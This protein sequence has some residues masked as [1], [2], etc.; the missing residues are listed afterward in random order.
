[1]QPDAEDEAIFNAARL[2]NAVE[3]IRSLPQGYNAPVGENGV[4]LSG[5]QRQRLAIA[6][7]VMRRPQ[8]L[9]LD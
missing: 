9:L 1:M 7:A 5:G 6:R 4:F 2:A 3:F 8:V